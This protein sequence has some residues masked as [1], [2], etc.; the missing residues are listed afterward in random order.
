M[1][2]VLASRTSEIR[3]FLA[4]EVMERGIAMAR[5]GHRIVQLGVGEPDFDAPDE[6]IDATVASLRA[7]E[8]HYTDSRGLIALREAI[9]DDCARRRG[10]RPDPARIVVTL[11]TSPAIAMV[12]QLLV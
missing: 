2:L 5:D 7:G 1:P 3:P 10:V 9:A 4:M 11:G 12:M 6:A 8:T